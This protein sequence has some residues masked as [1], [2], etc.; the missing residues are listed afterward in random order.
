MQE[1]EGLAL[2]VQSLMRNFSE[3][4]GQLTGDIVLKDTIIVQLQNEN[5]QL[6]Q[7]IAGYETTETARPSGGKKS[8]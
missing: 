8:K 1:N 7:R 6:R 5:D 3:R 4:I 2:D